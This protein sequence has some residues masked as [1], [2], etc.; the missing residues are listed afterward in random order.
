MFIDE[1]CLDIFLKLKKKID[2]ILWKWWNVFLYVNK[3]YID[4]MFL[5]WYINVKKGI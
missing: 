3:V 2:L 1:F 5:Y 4:W